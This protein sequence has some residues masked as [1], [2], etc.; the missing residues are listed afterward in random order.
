LL[1]NPSL[2]NLADWMT[3]GM[4]SANGARHKQ[5]LQSGSVYDYLN[6]LSSGTF[7]TVKGTFNPD[8]PLSFQHWLDSFGTFSLIVGVYK[9]AQNISTT[10]SS[11]VSFS[12]NKTAK[13]LS[14]WLGDGTK[15]IMNESGDFVFLS[16]DGV[17]RVRF[18]L[19]AIP[20]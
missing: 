9:A 7:D 5:A 2:I 17:R 15:V 18:D 8:K 11:N 4:L 13:E 1:D 14:G 6:W 20:F 3:Y 16:Q 10:Q 12:A 19:I